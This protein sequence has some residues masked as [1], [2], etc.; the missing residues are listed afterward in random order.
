[1]DYVRSISAWFQSL[2]WLAP[3]PL[4]FRAD[5]RAAAAKQDK[6]KKINNQKDKVVKIG[7]LLSYQVKQKEYTGRN[8][9]VIFIVF[10]ILKS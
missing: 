10:K 8:I 1:M 7:S 6:N 5:Y 9:C 2:P 4:L 3:D